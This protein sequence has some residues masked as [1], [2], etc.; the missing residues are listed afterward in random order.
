M[1]YQLAGISLTQILNSNFLISILSESPNYID[2]FLA[3]LFIILTLIGTGL[4]NIYFASAALETLIPKISGPKEFALIGLAG[5][6]AFTF[7]QISK[8][9]I[10]IENLANSYISSLAVVLL[11]SFLV[12]IVLRHRPRIIE[13]SISTACWLV[14]CVFSTVFLIKNSSSN[15]YSLSLGVQASA[16]VFLI[17]IF[18]EESIWAF[19]NLGK[20][21]KINS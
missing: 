15:I 7:I 21:R 17:I 3:L 9:V 14:G 13:K 11:I 18:I 5:T 8:P 6:A 19:R 1:L 12:T 20:E 2:F 16:L 10:F 4:I